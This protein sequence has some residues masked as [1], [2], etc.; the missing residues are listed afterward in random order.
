[1]PYEGLSNAI[2]KA[3]LALLPVNGRAKGVPGNFSFEEAAQLCREAKIPHLIPHHFGMFAFNTVDRAALEKELA[4][5]IVPNAGLPD[6][7]SW[8]S[9][10]M[11]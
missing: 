11:S 6:V 5:S 7:S 2:Q 3:D 8:F 4:R 10:N 9:L 1:V